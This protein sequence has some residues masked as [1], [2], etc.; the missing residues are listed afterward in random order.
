MSTGVKH[1]QALAS[2]DRIRRGRD[3]VPW[4]HGVR[5][6]LFNEGDSGSPRPTP[7]SPDAFAWLVPRP[8]P[9]NWTQLSLVSGTAVLS[10]PSEFHPVRSDPGAASVAV[11][12]HRSSVA[13]LNATPQPGDEQLLG[14]ARFRVNHLL[15]DDAVIVHE[16]ASVE[17]RP[18]RGGYGSCVID[19]YV[20][21]V[22]RHHFHEIA[23]IVRGARHVSVVIAA[24]PPS[25]W[26]RFGPTIER[27]VASFDVR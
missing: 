26:G 14:W 20:I 10:Y 18:F 1:A 6:R 17:D 7:H 12:K 3:V 9:S 16:V 11:V 22:G 4:D 27:A 2:I 21:T 5:R 25:D 23:C 19:D 13:Y 8:P 24:A 15:D